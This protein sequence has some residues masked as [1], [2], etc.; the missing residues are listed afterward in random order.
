MQF[1]TGTN[2]WAEANV[3]A[4]KRQESGSKGLRREFTREQVTE[5]V[6]KLKYRKAAG[7]DEMVNEFI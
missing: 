6:A 2:A 7:I 1:E 3:K 4:S 5:S